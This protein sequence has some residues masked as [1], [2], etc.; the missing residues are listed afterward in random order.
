MKNFESPTYFIDYHDKS[1]CSRIKSV[2]GKPP[3]EISVLVRAEED[4]RAPAVVAKGK[5]TPSGTFE[6]T[7]TIADCQQTFD[8]PYSDVIEAI[9][10]IWG[11]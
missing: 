1:N 3:K 6:V 2:E 5:L 11:V 8:I 4:R 10:A 9:D 7:V